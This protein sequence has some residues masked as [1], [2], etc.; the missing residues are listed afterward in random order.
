MTTDKYLMEYDIKPSV[1]RI[2]I[3]DYLKEHKTHPTADEIFNAL[4]PSMPTLSKT[5]VYNTLKL[6]TEQGA[7]LCIH[8]EEKNARFDGDVSRHA[9]F[10]CLGCGCI[11]DI[12]LEQLE[13]V[14]VKNI[15]ELTVVETHLYYKGYC[16]KCREVYKLNT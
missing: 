4:S 1:Q 10:I 14:T 9:H 5:T 8:I 15:D 6:F 16:K 3:M 2:A 12:S 13:S 7:A 11:Y